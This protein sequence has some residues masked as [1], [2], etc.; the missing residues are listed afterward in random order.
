M[1][2]DHGETLPERNS[3]SVLDR[4]L[5]LSLAF[6]LVVAIALSARAFFRQVWLIGG[7]KMA[8]A[9]CE[10]ALGVGAG[11]W[12]ITSLHSG[13]TIHGLNFLPTGLCGDVYKSESPISFYLGIGLLSLVSAALLLR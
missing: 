11:I 10:R 13:K 5:A 8:W 6:L 7:S 2:S 3:A 9:L 1:T 12:A 4:F